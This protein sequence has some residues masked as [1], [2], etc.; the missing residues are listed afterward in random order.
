MIQLEVQVIRVT[1]VVFMSLEMKIE[2]VVGQ[3]IEMNPIELM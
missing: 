2:Q 3:I 1:V